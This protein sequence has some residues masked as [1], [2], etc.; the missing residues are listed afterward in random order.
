MHTHTHTEV[1]NFGLEPRPPYEKLC[2]N[3]GLY[4]ASE[5]LARYDMCYCR[6]RNVG[7]YFLLAGVLPGPSHWEMEQTFFSSNSGKRLKCIE[8]TFA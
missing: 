7:N 3:V 8:A 5:L 1:E 4:L 2:L 6:L